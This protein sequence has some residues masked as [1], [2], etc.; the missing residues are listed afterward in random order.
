MAA[1][2]S[3]TPA[4]LHYLLTQLKQN[5]IEVFRLLQVAWTTARFRFLQRCVGPETTVEPRTRIVNAANV[6]I[7]AGCLLK[8]G[9]YLR[10]GSEGQIRIGDRAA[11]NCF[12]QIY[13]HGGV[14]IGEETQIG[15]GVLITTTDHDYVGSL[16]TRYKPVKIGRRVWIGANVTVLPGVTIGDGAV[17]GAGAVVTKDVPPHTVAVGIPARVVKQIGAAQPEMVTHDE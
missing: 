2:R 1:T 4:K 12:C 7:G 13:G 10:A 17:I 3:H 15:P 8:E 11:L 16:E 6:R 9:I 5:P 14:E